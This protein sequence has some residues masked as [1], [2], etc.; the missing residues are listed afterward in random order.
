V[1]DDNH[2]FDGAAPP[3]DP[4]EVEEE[5]PYVYHQEIVVVDGADGLTPEMLRKRK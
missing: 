1:S 4:R 2:P 3:P 5:V